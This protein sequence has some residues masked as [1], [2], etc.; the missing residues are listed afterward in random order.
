MTIFIGVDGG[1]DK[2]YTVFFDDST[3]RGFRFVGRPI[4]VHLEDKATWE[5]RLMNVLGTVALRAKRCTW[6][7]VSKQCRLCL[8][9]AGVTE[10]LQEG[11]LHQE[12]LASLCLSDEDHF[13]VI[14]DTWAVILQNS[15]ET[16]LKG[17]CAFADVGA[18]VTIAL[19]DSELNTKN[20]I[21]G[22]GPVIGDFGSLVQLA[23]DFL[24]G[25]GRILDR[26]ES[27]DSYSYL[28]RNASDRILQLPEAPEQLQEWFDDL[29]DNDAKTWHLQL[30]ELGRVLV[31]YANA[32]RDDSFVE[33]LLK[34]S[35]S[36]LLESIGIAVKR[37]KEQLPISLFGQMFSSDLYRSCVR[38]GLQQS[39]YSNIFLPPAEMPEFTPAL[40]ALKRSAFGE[41]LNLPAAT[42]E[43]LP[44]NFHW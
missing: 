15:T 8:C 34:K 26:N 24:R 17:V 29:R 19:G 1:H 37:T 38:S 42:F 2:S 3:R 4:N 10:D 35:A 18:S 25:V 23:I 9:L 40:G 27:L 33:C 39:Q 13:S 12:L 11:G 44:Q 31:Q 21:D 36:E 6:R 43:L 5:P 7:Q 14:D 28:V 41:P 20:K 30:A 22:W 32:Y 16:P